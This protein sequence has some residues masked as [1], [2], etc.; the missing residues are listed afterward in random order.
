MIE[1]GCDAF[2]C[3]LV[4]RTW[5]QAFQPVLWGHVETANDISPESMKRHAHY[6]RSLSLADLSGLENVLDNCSRLETLILWPDAFEDEEDEE[7]EDEEIDEDFEGDGEEEDD[8]IGDI[9]LGGVGGVGVEGGDGSVALF[10][11]GRPD[12]NAGGSSNSLVQRYLPLPPLPT[13][14]PMEL[15]TQPL[16]DDGVCADGGGQDQLLGAMN[17]TFE[18]DGDAKVR[19]DS[20]FSD[21]TMTLTR[22]DG[23]IGQ[24]HSPLTKLLLHNRN[25]TRLEVYVERKS[26]GGSFWRALAVPPSSS[27]VLCPC[28]RLSTFQ[29]LVNLQ[30]YKH[31]KSFFQ[32]CMRLESLTLENCSLR[33]LDVSYYTT[34]L[35]FPRM[36]ELKF[37]RIRDTSLYCQLLIMK[38]CPE[39]MSLDWRV[40]R[41][42]FPVE[43]FCEALR[44]DCWPKLKSLVLLESR[45]TDEEM[46]RI[47]WSTNIHFNAA[48]ANHD[49]L[50]VDRLNTTMMP[51]VHT[52]A[53]H[54]LSRFE[55]P[56]SDFGLQAFRALKVRGHFWTLRHLDLLQCPGF[57]S[58]MAIEILRGCPLLESFDGHQLLVRDIIAGGRGHGHGHGHGY[59]GRVEDWACT[60]IKFLNLHITGFAGEPE[61]DRRA[62]WQ[63]FAHLARL[64]QLV[65]L[66]IGGRTSVR[67][68]AGLGLSPL[69]TSDAAI[70]TTSSPPA[71]T[72]HPN[73]AGALTTRRG[74]SGL[75][76]RLRSGL[77]QLR[78][79]KKLRMLRF[80]GLEQEM[81]TED[82]NWMVENFPDLKHIQGRLHTDPEEQTRLEQMLER[83]NITAWTMYDSQHVQKQRN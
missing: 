9:R 69:S 66:S 35:H 71:E 6:I 52:D 8:A 67:T 46:A 47:L 65:Y 51:V 22:G 43:E 57:E 80:T 33:Q 53:A 14:H 5:Q 1:S 34:K 82:V 45:L 55:V 68:I 38:Q 10:T 70:A 24:Q 27:T 79:L 44:E 25:L 23:D 77:G 16:V 39:L 40:P 78:T 7:D 48:S 56:R 18:K 15:H 73:S 50:G 75:D 83:H 81:T 29:S 60:G 58:W 61:Q 21:D 54:G 36:K 72:S 3:V 11:K 4:S 30:V 17:G 64:D 19:R 28:P 63:V 31:V 62:H 42:G 74:T 76:L 12:S 59:H 32:M 13:P 20:G 49:S 26:P 41:L 2:S 37:S